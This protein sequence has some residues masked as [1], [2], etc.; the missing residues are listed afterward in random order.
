MVRFHL[1][2]ALIRRRPEPF[3]PEIFPNSYEEG[4]RVRLF[5]KPTKYC[6]VLH[7]FPRAA[8]TKEKAMADHSSTL[9]WKIPWTEELGRLQ[10]SGSHRVRHDRSNLAA[11]AAKTKYH[12][13]GG[14]KQQSFIPSQFGRPE[15]QNQDISRG[16]GPCESLREGSFLAS[17][18][19][20][21]G[22]SLTSLVFLNSCRM[23]LTFSSAIFSA[24][25]CVLSYSYKRTSCKN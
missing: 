14:K 18:L 5:T 2:N 13:L 3:N 24:S 20:A 22:C 1:A 6:W 21:G 11:V 4:R 16:H 9:A 12:Q 19:A 7:L 23:T 10:S 25:P 17:L 15:V 8:K